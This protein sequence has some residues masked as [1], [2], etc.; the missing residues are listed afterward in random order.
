MRIIHNLLLTKLKPR[1]A[2]IMIDDN[3]TYIGLVYV[4]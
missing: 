1:I 2:A 3:V 4:W